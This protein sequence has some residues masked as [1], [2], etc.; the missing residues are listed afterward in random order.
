M[1]KRSIKKENMIIAFLFLLIPTLMLFAGYYIYPYPL[2]EISEELIQIPIFLGLILLGI[3]F[4]IKKQGITN[5]IKISGW[6]VF[7]F[8]WSTQPAILYFS[9]GGDVFN[10]AVCVIGVYVLFYLAYHEWLSFIRKETLGCL[11]WIAGAS[12]VAGIIYYGIERTALAPW[13]IGETAKQS[14][15]VLNTIIGNTESVGTD[16]YLNGEYVV[17]IIFACTA[18]QAMVIFIGMIGVL[19]KV[20][21]KRKIYGL[22]VTLVPI[23]ILNLFRNSLVVFLVGNNITDFNVAHNIISKAGALL[24]LI[25]L[26]FI[27]IKI[28]PEVFDEIIG[29]TDLYKRNGPLEQV[30]KKIWRKKTK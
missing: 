21:V 27:I 19:H 28:I 11:N 3:G 24:T 8:F 5:L 22:M 20:D 17:T 2:D 6:M 9:E 16:I 7:A 1:S 25:I 23:Y 15:W 13:M 26:L 30:S 10:A 4:F 14:A 29:L 12:F 18:I